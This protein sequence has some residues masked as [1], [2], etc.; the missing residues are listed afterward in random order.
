[1]VNGDDEGDDGVGLFL[2]GRSN[3]DKAIMAGEELWVVLGQDATKT[4][5]LSS[6]ERK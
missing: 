6:S 3:V 1:M 5:F 4:F 2:C